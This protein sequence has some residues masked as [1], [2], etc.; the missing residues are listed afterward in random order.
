MVT[1]N[2][3]N[4]ENGTLK[5]S[6]KKD[7]FESKGYSSILPPKNEFNEN[8]VQ[9]QTFAS[10]NS[11][12]KN[13][14]SKE[15][16]KEL[17]NFFEPSINDDTVTVFSGIDAVSYGN[18][19]RVTKE[20][21]RELKR[22]KLL[23]KDSWVVHNGHHLT[24]VGIYLFTVFVFLRP[25]EL[26]PSLAFLSG[27]TLFIALATLTVFLPTQLSSK[28]SIS[29]WTTEVK[30]VL[31][32]VFFALLTMPIA[33][34]REMAWEKFNDPFIKTVLMFI[35]MVNVVRTR[36]RLISLIWVSIAT[37]VYLSYIA[38]ILFQKGEF[39][40]DGYRVAVDVIG[41]LTA[42][43]NDMA[44][45][46]ATMTPIVIA[47]GIAAKNKLFG[48]IC[49]ALAM[50]F[51]AANM[52]TYSRGGFLGLLA[53]MAVL[54]WKFGRGNRLRV[55][56]AAILSGGL[57]ILVAPG[58]YG[59]RIL[60]IFVPE[61]DPNGS[62]SARQESLIRSIIVTLRN[63]WGIGIGNS[64]I[65]GITNLET[66]NAYTQVSSEL[67]VL[68]LIAYL[69]FIIS[70]LRKLGAIEHQMFVRRDFSWFYYMSIGLQGSIIA[71][72]VSSFFASV[73]YSWYVYYLITYAI[74]LRLIYQIEQAKE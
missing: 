34:N 60:S 18:R 8:T 26:V 48:L 38:L 28:N 45:H 31:L 51:I 2:S 3:K 9:S 55:S 50:L 21:K 6:H 64:P 71:Y 62:S 65:V 7:V 11:E 25:Y 10:G 54:T 27:A 29:I 69:V 23:S 16:T 41:G 22:K 57:F 74:S 33:I 4:F 13:G 68:A 67:G 70:P 47:L 43:P 72:M 37:S 40:T 59:L 56:F 61:L 35:V 52:V 1:R 30:C 73:A 24:F 20:K 53:S 58:N 17:K 19:Q 14:E 39:K 42:N 49:F 44:L 66:H 63:P 32:L 12:S 5:P 46:L 15:T 36:M